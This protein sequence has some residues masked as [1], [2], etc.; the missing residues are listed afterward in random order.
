MWVFFNTDDSW[1]LSHFVNESSL[2]INKRLT[3]FNQ[4]IE[5]FLKI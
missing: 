4:Y 1:I 2:R 3:K 5:N